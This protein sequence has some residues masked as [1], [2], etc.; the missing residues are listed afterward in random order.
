VKGGPYSYS[1]IA[2]ASLFEIQNASL[3]SALAAAAR[4]NAMVAT[5]TAAHL[6]LLP[7]FC[8]MHKLITIHR[9][10]M[11]PIKKAICLQII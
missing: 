8:G 5:A 10:K 1:Y 3:I 4:C 7:H 9:G 11:L 2:M 6:K